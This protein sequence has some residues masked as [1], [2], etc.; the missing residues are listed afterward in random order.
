MHNFDNKLYVVASVHKD[1]SSSKAGVD[2]SELWI[3]ASKPKSSNKK[4][5]AGGFSGRPGL[6]NDLWDV[7]RASAAR[8]RPQAMHGMLHELRSFWRFLD[9]FENFLYEQGI[10]D[11]EH[12]D[13]VEL[14]STIHGERWLKPLGGGWPA[15][16][17]EKYRAVGALIQESLH[18]RGRPPVFWAPAPNPDRIKRKEIPTKEQGIELVRLLTKKAHLIW[19]RWEQADVMAETGRNMLGRTNEELSKLEVTEAD[20]HATYRVV[21][22]QLGDPAPALDKMTDLLGCTRHLPSWWPTHPAGHKRAG[23]KVNLENDVLPGLYPTGEDL[24]CLSSLF[25]A[26]SGWNPTTLF[27]LDCSSDASWFRTYGEGLVWLHSY[28]ERGNSW[29]DTISPERHSAHCYQIVLRLRDRNRPLLEKL[30]DDRSRSDLPD[31]AER[32]PWLSANNS[33][34]IQVLGTHSL[35]QMRA[36]LTTISRKLNANGFSNYPVFKPSDLRDV[37]AEAIHRGGNYSIFLTQITLG[38]K[39]LYTTRRYLRSL[40]WRRESE[41]KLNELVSGVFSQIEV[42]RIIDFSLLRA[43][44]DGIEVTDE[45][46]ARL[47]RYRKNR[48]YSGLFCSDPTYPP[49]W[50]DPLN[51]LDGKEVCVQ[52]HRCPACPNGK[53]FKDSLP[54]LAKCTAELEWKQQ[55]FGDVRWYQSTDSLDLDVFRATLQQ[56]PAEQV[57]REVTLWREKIKRGEHSIVITAAGVH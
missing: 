50:I 23:S 29:Q 5:W 51:P 45:Q 9:A 37:F 14:I 34:K 41:K 13:G 46:I 11:V 53:V 39:S 57:E 6:A 30:Q 56:W 7:V 48:T 19:K 52:G 47:E 12:V 17:P 3:G 28:K 35:A 54:H 1:Y 21:I 20:I 40:A 16:R 18:A 4:T 32:S 55:E 31:I 38:H 25:M 42:H 15:A 49:A 44:M 33:K 43:K 36:Y 24:Y 2:F 22:R 8:K 27:A 10:T 26:L